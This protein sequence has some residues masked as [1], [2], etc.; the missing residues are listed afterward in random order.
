MDFDAT[1]TDI[2]NW[3]LPVKGLCKCGQVLTSLGALFLLPTPI[4]T[5]QKSVCE[6]ILPGAVEEAS[7]FFSHGLPLQLFSALLFQSKVLHMAVA[8]SLVGVAC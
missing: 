7:A 3:V 4:Y 5:V 8:P 1:R 2:G 6:H